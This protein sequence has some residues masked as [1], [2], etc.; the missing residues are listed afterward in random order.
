LLRLGWPIDT[1]WSA[2]KDGE[3]LPAMAPKATAMRVWRRG[4]CVFHKT[5]DAAEA[6]ALE[7]LRE[8]ANFERVC[9]IVA[10]DGSEEVGAE[11]AFRMLQSWL[12]DVVLVELFPWPPSLQGKGE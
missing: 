10:D 2:V 3:E 6:A 5:I 9:E 11:A 8:G 1:V 7:A 4:L 12:A